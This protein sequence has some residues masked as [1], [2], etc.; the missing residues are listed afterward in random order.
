MSIKSE[1]LL[2]Y[3]RSK[4]RVARAQRPGDTLDQVVRDHPILGFVPSVG[5]GW[6]HLIRAMCE[7]LAEHGLPDGLQVTDV[8]EKYGELRAGTVPYFDDVDEIIE[9]Y[10]TVSREICDV[11]GEPGKLTG[12]RWVATRCEEH[13]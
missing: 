7:H 3:A 9:T 10:V 13:A 2:T 12:S 8:K 1:Y 6:V 4:V 11:C 5:E